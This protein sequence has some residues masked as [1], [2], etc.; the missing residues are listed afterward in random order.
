MVPVLIVIITTLL[1][2]AFFSGMEIAFV[3]SNKLQLEIEKKKNNAFGKIIGIFLRNPGQYLTTIL[4]GNNIA[5]VIYSLYMSL[6]LSGI[7]RY[8]GY[9]PGDG[10]VIV[11]TVVSTI[12][13]IFLGE[14]IPKSIV[15]GNPNF[16]MKLFY[17]PL[18]LIYIILY[19]IARFTTWLAV[20]MMRA[21]GI[22]IKHGS[23]LRVFDRVDLAHMVEE[24]AE[25]EPEKTDHELKIFQN[26][27]DFSDLR[28]RDCMVPRVDVEAVEADDTIEELSKRFIDTNYSRI[29]VYEDNID[30]I[31]GYVNTKSLFTSPGT[32]R[33]ILKKV[34]YV[35]E[36]LPAQ[37]LLGMLIK[38]N[39]TIA[40]VIDEFGG[41]AGVVSM[42]DA[43]EEIFGEIEDEHD[44]PDMVE[45]VI[46][47]NSIYIFSGRLEVDYLNDKYALGIPESEEYDTL[48]GYIIYNH[49]GIPKRGDVITVGNMEFLALRGSRS[50]LDLVRVTVLSD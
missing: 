47:E 16:F 33:E 31:I 46:T 30:N 44:Q 15:R 12:V 17:A 28:V 34:D 23:N 14:F 32:I 18:F 43:L 25:K 7:A 37:R 22:K 38:N 29:F 48:A 42:E 39:R 4:V 1:F 3:S 27:L 20:V 36:S 49:E 13:I 26:V 5:L 10:Y 24:A 19:P 41:T 9:D 50:T 6:L 21:V 11:E 8:Y 2:S 35:P 45:K 40:V